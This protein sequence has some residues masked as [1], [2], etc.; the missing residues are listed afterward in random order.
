MRGQ[1]NESPGGTLDDYRG[2]LQTLGRR[3]AIVDPLTSNPQS[4]TKGSDYASIATWQNPYSATSGFP[5]RAGGLTLPAMSAMSW[6][7]R[8]S[9][10]C[11]DH[12]SSSLGCLF[13]SKIRSRERW[14]VSTAQRPEAE[15]KIKH[16]R[17]DGQGRERTLEDG[18]GEVGRPSN[19]A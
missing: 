3:R 7:R 2:I 4:P 12:V 16:W 9:S 19:G 17:D 10:H 8:A 15:G 6:S 11:C 13:R 1:P 14:K 5:S 18:G